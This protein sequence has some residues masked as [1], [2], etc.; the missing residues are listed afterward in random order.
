MEH[1]GLI[2]LICKLDLL[3][4][5]FLLVFYVSSIRAVIIKPAFPYRD[6]FRVFKKLAVGIFIEIFSARSE[7][8]TFLTEFFF[9]MKRCRSMDRVKTDD[10]IHPLRILIGHLYSFAGG[11]Y[12][13]ADIYNPSVV[14]KRAPDNLVAVGVKGTKIYMRMYVYVFKSHDYTPS[15]PPPPLGGGKM[16]ITFLIFSI[17]LSILSFF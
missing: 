2:K 12:L 7:L 15:P 10:R 1:Q 8:G 4:E 14:I 13:S 11:V 16:L 3:D 5:I 9:V 17:T 6:N